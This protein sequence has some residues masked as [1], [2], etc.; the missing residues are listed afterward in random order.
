MNIRDVMLDV[1][2]KAKESSYCIAKL[3]TIDKNN[4]LQHMALGIEENIDYIQEE[5]KKDLEYAKERGLSEAFID[6]LLLNESRIKSMAQGIREIAQLPDPVGEYVWTR[7]RPNGLQISKVRTPL[8]VVAV[9]YESRPN[10]TADAASLCLKSGNAII[11]RGGKEALNSN[12]VIAKILQ[13]SLEVFSLP[14]EIISMVKIT[15]HQAVVALV[16]L[17]QY[18][19]V[20][21]PRGGES[22][23]NTIRQESTIPVIFHAKGNCHLYIDKEANI[24]MAHK[25]TINAKVQRPGVCNAIET[26]LVHKDIARDVLPNLINDLKALKVEIRGCPKTKDIVNDIKEANEEDWYEEYLS[27]ILAVKVVESME[28]AMNHIRKYGSL[29]SEGIITNSISR[30]NRFAQEV[31][32]SAIFINS[33]TR[34]NDGNQF[35]LGAEIGISTQKLHV[36][37]PMGLE[38]LTST[39]YVV[40][41]N[42]HI[43]E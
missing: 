19:D 33:S 4:L 13:R 20:V 37:G 3:S 32:A 1:A 18:I 11:L 15:D 28:E 29:H 8:G 24:E 42:G 40:L 35:G 30:A 10:V 7:R 34:F 26:L 39:K 6:R 43:R 27:L 25:I 21:I 23:V 5:N 41:G 9:I 17:D 16:K 36:R 31:D 14:K 38:D 12:C 22:L 2:K